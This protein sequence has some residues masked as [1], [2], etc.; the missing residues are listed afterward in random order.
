[1]TSLKDQDSVIRRMEIIG[2]AAKN[3]PLELKIL[4]DLEKDT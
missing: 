2:E 1:M 4:E 3:I